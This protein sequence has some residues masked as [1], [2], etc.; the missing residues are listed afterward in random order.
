MT[1]EISSRRCGAT[2]TTAGISDKRCEAINA[3]TGPNTG[4][5]VRKHH[6][7]LLIVRRTAAAI[8][9]VDMGTLL[10]R[11]A[12]IAATKA[13]TSADRLAADMDRR[14]PVHFLF[15]PG[16]SSQ[17]SVPSSQKTRFR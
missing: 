12:R 7:P 3:A 10:D 2:E 16:S 4:V 11:S 9:V 1:A 17:F 15:L 8:M 5:R 6:V 13:T 14:K